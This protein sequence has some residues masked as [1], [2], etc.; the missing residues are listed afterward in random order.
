MTLSLMAP[1]LAHAT[2]ITYTFESSGFPLNATTPLLAKAPDVGDPTFRTDFTSTG[3]SFFIGNNSFPLM[4]G[5]NLGDQGGQTG[6]LILTFS[7][8]VTGVD[9]DFAIFSP[10]GAGNFQAVITGGSTFSTPS[11]NQGGTSQGGEFIFSSLTPF[12][13]LTLT[14]HNSGLAA[15]AFVIDNLTLTEATAT[16]VP[17]PASMLLLGTGLIGF[18]ARRRRNRR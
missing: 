6:S 8:P 10:A 18:A 4:S 14:A 3:N 16:P 7:T 1:A 11:T 15:T 9:V 13:Q 12:T 5:Q 2:S 17:E